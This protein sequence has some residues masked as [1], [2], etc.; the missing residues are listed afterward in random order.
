MVAMPDGDPSAPSTSQV[1]LRRIVWPLLACI[2]VGLAIYVA[3]TVRTTGDYGNPICNGYHCDNAAPAI[4][5]GSRGHIGAFFDR[6]PIMG[7]TSLVVRIPAVA[8]ARAADASDLD[9]YRAG[10]AV[11]IALALL[12][13]CWLAHQAVTRGIGPVPVAGFLAVSV[14]AASWTQ[15]IGVGHPEEPLAAALVVAAIVLAATD[16]T[17]AAGVVLGL[18]IATKEWALLAV[19]PLAVVAAPPNWRRLFVPALMVAALLIAPMAIAAPSA[20]KDAHVARVGSI[21]VYGSPFSVWWRFGD[22]EVT[23]HVSG[24]E[25]YVVHPP[26]AATRLVRPVTLVLAAVLS[27]LYWRRRRD[28]SWLEPLALLALILLLRDV[29][30]TVTFAYHHIPMLMTLACWE[31]FAR[32]RLPVVAAAAM[33]CLQITFREIDDFYT[34]NTVYLAWTIPLAVYLA[35]VSFRRRV[36]AAVPA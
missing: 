32:R 31:V 25:I 10:A 28:A 4:E 15:A 34:L 27:L 13:V 6:Q 24:G 23:G 1:E 12:I 8:L 17:L 29:L 19:P 7:P 33:V 3:G 20:F 9:R 16:R 14:V 21:G 22:R 5:A 30:D 26:K 35:V 11:C 36:S 2:L 18:A